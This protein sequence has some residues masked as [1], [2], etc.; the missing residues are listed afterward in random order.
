MIRKIELGL[1][2][3]H[4]EQCNYMKPELLKKLRR[5]IEQTGNYEPLTVRPHPWEEGQFQVINGHNR[6]RVLRAIGCS[7]ATCEVWDIDE[8]QTRLYLATLNQLSG[9]DIPER[10]VPLLESLLQSHE[11][12]EL[13]GLLPERA[14]DITRLEALAALDL[15]DLTPSER[16]AAEDPEVPVIMQFTLLEPHAKVVDLA[17]DLIVNSLDGDCT[18]G[19]ALVRLAR[20][21][22]A[23][24]TPTAQEAAAKGSHAG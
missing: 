6:L 20:Y 22:L 10:R 11:V 23:R 14:S 3:P 24:C 17:L 21:F 15:D 1:L 13:A 19:E 18:R 16:S 12:A 5:H 2:K 8:E 4:P 9:S 7:S